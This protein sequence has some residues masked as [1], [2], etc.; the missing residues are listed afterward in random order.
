MNY[1]DLHPGPYYNVHTK[2]L[3]HQAELQDL[4]APYGAFRSAVITIDGPLKK[5]LCK[6]G[7]FKQTQGIVLAD[8]EGSIVMGVPLLDAPDSDLL[9]HETKWPVFLLEFSSR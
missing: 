9:E 3:D 4:H 7:T 5:A 1:T 2:V 8:E 6:H